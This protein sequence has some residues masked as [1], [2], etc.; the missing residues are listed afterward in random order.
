[1][2][3]SGNTELAEPIAVRPTSET[4]EYT[5]HTHV[6]THTS[7]EWLF[8]PDSSNQGRPGHQGWAGRLAA[9]VLSP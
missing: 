1:M 8:G 5:T 4:G 2:T 7:L 9:R 6:H 3:R